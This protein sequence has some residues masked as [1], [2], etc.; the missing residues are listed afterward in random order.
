MADQPA[1][2]TLLPTL[3]TQNPAPVGGT[4]QDR[5]TTRRE[6]VD[7]IM[8]VFLQVLPSNYVSQ[9]TGPF[10]TIQFQAAAEA[11]ADFQITAQEVF[12]DA[13]YDYT[14][15]EFLFQILG[16]LVFPD[17][18]TDGYPDLKGDTTYREFLKQM[19]LL[20]LQGATKPTV[21]S[22]LEL[23]SDATFTVIEKVIA[24]RNAKKKVWN[25]TTGRY[26]DVPGS[27]WGFDDQFEFEINVSY[28]D[29]VTGRQRFPEDP[30]DLQENVRIV[31]RALK[32]AHTIYEYRH[33]FTEAF[34]SIASASPSWEMSNYHYADFRKFCCGAKNVAGTAGVTWTDKALFSDTSREFDQIQAGADLVVL[35]GPNSI[36]AGGIE[37]TSVSTDRYAVGRYRVRD[38][39]AFPVGTDATPRAY[40]TSPSGFTGK[41]TVNVDVIEDA[42]S[43][44]VLANNLLKVTDTT[45][46]RFLAGEFFICIGSDL[47]T[48]VGVVVFSADPGSGDG[49]EYL[50]AISG[51]DPVGRLKFGSQLLI[52]YADAA[53]A[54]V[55]DW[56]SAV[57]GEALTF[58]EGLNAGTYR[59]KTLL[60]NSGGPL[61]DATGPGTQVR[62][63][64]SLIRTERRMKQAATGQQYTVVVDRLGV[65][66]PQVVDGEDASVF[67]VL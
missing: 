18:T 62:V 40:T 59:L 1:D 10:Y 21:E 29:P 58:T 4:G 46:V 63:A 35:S 27:A 32:P 31:M 24:A 56:A 33:L 65:Q 43:L 19:V 25:P 60:G 41:A 61:G 66:E 42:Y 16:A 38:V 3:L 67:F 12:S 45:A 11:L 7:A 49:V 50:T 26:D 17:A 23:L 34:G 36:H 30:F 53:V 2:K 48:P 9:V 15:S 6:Q 13:D 14:R 52:D 20:L 28:T 8:G 54:Y 44:G 39:L 57:E 55:G 47:F 64:Y 37:G 5:I 51:S 22:G